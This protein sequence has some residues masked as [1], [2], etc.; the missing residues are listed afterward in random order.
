MFLKRLNVT[1]GVKL[2]RTFFDFER[3]SQR[4]NWQEKRR[5]ATMCIYCCVWSLDSLVAQSIFCLQ[6]G[7]REKH[8]AERGCVHNSLID[9]SD[10]GGKSWQEGG[11]RLWNLKNVFIDWLFVFFRRCTYLRE[12][13]KNGFLSQATNTNYCTAPKSSP[14]TKK[15]QRWATHLR[16]STKNGF[17]SQ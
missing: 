10:E 11:R 12:S 9:T 8:P 1:F 7:A 4:I 15:E 6:P 5:E 3:S 2:T 16:E 13:T 14:H 17:L